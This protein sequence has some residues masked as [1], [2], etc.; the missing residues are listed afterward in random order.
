M[1]SITV[2]QPYQPSATA[3][4]TW[5]EWEALT[6]IEKASARIEEMQCVA[7]RWA[8]TVWDESLGVPPN[9]ITDAADLITLCDRA[10][11]ALRE[12]PEAA[13]LACMDAQTK[14]AELNRWTLVS[15]T[16]KRQKTITRP[17]AAGARTVNAKRSKDADERRKV[18]VEKWNKLQSRPARERAGIIAAQ[19]G[20]PVDTVRRHIKKAGLR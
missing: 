3:G 8:G 7:S 18:V 19:T 16:Q 10:K 14:A 1:K 9:V 13:I 5:D 17:K 4:H 15:E 12:S 11:A 20:I 6:P 2:K